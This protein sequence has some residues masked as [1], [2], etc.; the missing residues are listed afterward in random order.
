MSASTSNVE[1]IRTCQGPI[2]SAPPSETTTPEFVPVITAQIDDIRLR[3]DGA[4][5]VVVL[6]TSGGEATGQ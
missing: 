1:Y 5:S 2:V 4:Q 3:D 6:G